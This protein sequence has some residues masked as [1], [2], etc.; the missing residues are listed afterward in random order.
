M[1]WLTGV[2]PIALIVLACPLI[3][4]FMMRG[5]HGEHGH[6]ADHS[7]D[8]GLSADGSRQ[9]VEALKQDVAGLRRE[10]AARSLPPSATGRGDRG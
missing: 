8:S 10:L 9:E 4:W 3:M 6:A 7:S 1:E 2:V 5:M